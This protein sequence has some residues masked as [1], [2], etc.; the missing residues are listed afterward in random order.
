MDFRG[1]G[2]GE[3]QRVNVTVTSKDISLDDGSDVDTT[4]SNLVLRVK[5]GELKATIPKMRRF[6]TVTFEAAPELEENA[7][8][9]SMERSMVDRIDIDRNE[10]ITEAEFVGFWAQFFA[11]SDKNGDEL[12]DGSEFPHAA[13]LK[14]KDANKDGK[15]TLDEYKEIYRSQFPG[16]DRNNDGVVDAYDNP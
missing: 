6:T 16:H 14:A 8:I 2:F 15:L 5:D 10:I 11:S 13:P 4:V 3:G 7:P 1:E 9:T 12:L